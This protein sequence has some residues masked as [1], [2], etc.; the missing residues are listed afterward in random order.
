M[1]GKQYEPQIANCVRNHQDSNTN[2]CPSESA[3]DLASTTANGSRHGML[4]P[5][6]L[7]QLCRDL[8]PSALDPRCLLS[9]GLVPKSRTWPS[10]MANS[11]TIDYSHAQPPQHW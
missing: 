3:C 7:S 9:P 8:D 11:I 6:H 4:Q 2:A 10:S 5:A 1:N